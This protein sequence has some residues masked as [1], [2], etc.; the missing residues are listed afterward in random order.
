MNAFLCGK[1]RVLWDVA[2]NTAYDH[3]MNFLAPGSRDMFNANSKAVDYLY[4][5][6]CESEFEQVW[7][8]DLACR[9]WEQLKNAHAGNAQVQARLFVTYRREYENF[10]HLPGKSIDAMFQRFMVIVN[11]MRANVVM[12]PYDD[13]DRAVKL[14]HS[15]DHTVWSGKVEAILESENYETLTVDE[16]FSKFKSSEVDRGVRAKIENPTDP[17]S[18]ALVSGSRTNANMSSRQFSLSCLVSM[19]DEEFDVLGEEDLALLSRRFERMYT[20]RKN[21]RRSSGMC[22]RFGKHGHFIAECPEAMEVKP[23][24]KHHSRNDHMHCSRDD[25]KGKNKSERRPRKSGGHKKK[26]R[27][28]V[29]SASDIDSSSCYSS[30][31]SSDEEENRH[32]GKCSSKNINGLCFAAQGFCG[33][34]QSTASKKSNK[35]DWGS[36]SEEEVNNSPSFLIAENARLNDL[37]DNRDDMLR[38]TNKEKREYRTLLGEAKENVVELE[39]LLGDARAQIDS[40][41]FAPVV[42]NKP[43]CTNCS[44]FLG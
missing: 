11:N 28:M 37:L 29:A 8:E 35:D 34:A 26:E 27:A 1:G 7:T 43:E 24:H 44:I 15:L 36:D 12:L 2:V 10:T 38:K 40:V 42:T 41:K 32:K 31:S 39:S 23:E 30:S 25:Y 17:H 14:L 19:P 6:L 9:I 21:T 5:S 33:M 13:H 16:L 22:Y 18:L 4:R 20:N 3:P